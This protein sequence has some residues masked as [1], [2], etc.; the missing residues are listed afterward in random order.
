MLRT[1]LKSTG[2]PLVGH[3]KFRE[4]HYVLFTD[5]ISSKVILFH[6]GKFGSSSV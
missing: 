4:I 1:I 3:E 5:T 2:F 6:Q